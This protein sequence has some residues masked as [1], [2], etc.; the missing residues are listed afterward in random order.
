MKIFQKFMSFILVIA[1]LCSFA[2]VGAAYTDENKITHL[3]AVNVLT[4]LGIMEGYPDG[5]MQPNG[6]V[7]RA[8]MAKL[9]ATIA[10]SGKDI[11]SIYSGACTFA[12]SKSHWAAGYIAYCAAQGIIDGRSET[13]FDPNGKVTVIEAT[14][15]VLGALGYESYKE[16][17][18]GKTWASYVMNVANN[19]TIL[20]NTDNISTGANATRQ[21]IAQMLF[22]ALSNNMV[23]Y[24]GGTTI[25]I[26]GVSMIT[27]AQREE[28]GRTLAAARFPDLS[29][30]TVREDAFGRKQT[31]YTLKD[32]EISVITE[33]PLYVAT[34]VTGEKI[35]DLINFKKV[36]PTYIKNGEEVTVEIKDDKTAVFGAN[37]TT[38][39]VYADHIVEI[40]TYIG[41]VTAYSKADKIITID[42]A[43]TYKATF[44][45]DAVVVYTKTSAGIQSVELA[46]KFYATIEGYAANTAGDVSTIYIKGE[47][48]PMSKNHVVTS[49][50]VVNNEYV[51][52]VDADGA[53][54]MIDGVEYVEEYSYAFIVD[55]DKEATLFG[56]DNHYVK[57]VQ[58][59]G[60][61]S[62]V[63]ADKSYEALEGQFVSYTLSKGLF[64]FAA[65]TTVSNTA[66]VTN[67]VAT[68]DTAVANNNTIFIIA[69][70][71]GNLVYTGVRNVPT[72]TGKINYVVDKDGLITM[73]YATDV[74]FETSSTTSNESLVIYKTGK[75]NKIIIS[76]EYYVVNAIVNGVNS[77]IKIAPAV[78]DEF[79]NGYN[80][81]SKATIDENGV[82]DSVV[83]SAAEAITSYTAYSGGVIIINGTPY[84][85]ENVKTYVY[86]N[87][88]TKQDISTI[89]S[90]TTGF[91]FMENGFVVAL[92]FVK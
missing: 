50:P 32:K 55:T 20:N 15:M 21:I 47:A 36:T 11:G 48:Y 67:R 92:Y 25:V 38:I 3:E 81:C 43:L 64:K 70:D 73:M 87:G 90:G 89:K 39:E 22:N 66:T 26:G 85:V 74:T 86:N 62:V 54:M 40:D 68:V 8:E 53:I 83:K 34:T 1:I 2:I 9:I 59:D 52:Y 88:F 17:F 56:A 45:K 58:P 10:N 72:F 79:V 41:V 5:S 12:D 35:H 14:K 4:G 6:E 61:V 18:T 44:D 19:T 63:K 80:F 29:E 30:P 27:S 46:H 57:M 33:T 77:E 51:I 23:K 69:T 82:Y 60:S 24:V 71:N 65:V 78:Y 16:Q 84:Y 31:V 28:T 42:N 49:K 13:I 7:T 91:Y 37:G 76:Y 75:E